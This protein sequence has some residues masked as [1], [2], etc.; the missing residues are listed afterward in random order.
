MTRSQINERFQDGERFYRRV[1]V[2]RRAVPGEL[3]PRR[4]F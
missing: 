1:A 4:A 2:G 3:Y